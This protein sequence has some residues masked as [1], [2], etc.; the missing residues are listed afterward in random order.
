LGK[1]VAFY[2]MVKAEIV[3]PSGCRW[4]SPPT[5]HALTMTVPGLRSNARW[6]AEVFSDIT[7]KPQPGRQARLLDEVRRDELLTVTR[8][9]EYTPQF[10]RRQ[11]GW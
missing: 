5:L 8:W 9:I 4:K 11:K 7:D 10:P 6:T 2:K 1:N 3:W